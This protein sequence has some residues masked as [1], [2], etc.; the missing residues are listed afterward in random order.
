MLEVHMCTIGLHIS[1]IYGLTHCSDNKCAGVVPDRCGSS[2][3]VF[4]Y[5][6]VIIRMKWR[7]NGVN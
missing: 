5:P 7:R 2:L 3:D 6:Q 4:S 1:C